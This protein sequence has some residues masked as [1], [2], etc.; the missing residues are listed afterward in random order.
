MCNRIQFNKI[1]QKYIPK[2]FVSYVVDLVIAEQVI[3][4]IVPSRK[5]KMGDYRPPYRD[6]P[7]RIS[8]NFDLNPYAFLITTLHEF[9]H[10]HTYLRYK[11][12]VKAH[13]EEWQNA[14]R[15]LL[16]PVL[17]TKKLPK[18]IET[19]VLNSLIKVKASSCSDIKLYKT[20][21]QYD[22]KALKTTFLDDLPP[23][24]HFRLQNRIFKKEKLLRTRYLCVD[25][26]SGKKFYVSGVAEV[27]RIEF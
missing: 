21:R 23:L 12:K 4:N 25:I 8:V 24:S 27:E 6:K 3:F 16:M 11:N 13:G 26:N 2:D 18:D 9:A 5:T 19:A 17:E 20:L 10:M 1:F 7:H 15:T 22:K 14:Y